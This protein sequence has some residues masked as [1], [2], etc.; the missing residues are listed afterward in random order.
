MTPQ[1]QPP[2]STAPSAP[3]PSRL[4]LIEPF[5]PPRKVDDDEAAAPRKLPRE[6]PL[7]RE[8]I[9]ELVEKVLEEELERLREPGEPAS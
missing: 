5:D 3:S 2:P 1:I 7:S 8:E 9:D 4:R 6:R